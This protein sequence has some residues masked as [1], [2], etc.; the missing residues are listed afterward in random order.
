MATS[1]SAKLYMNESFPLHTAAYDTIGENHQVCPICGTHDIVLWGSRSGFQLYKC[2][3][4]TH[5][6][7]DIGSSTITE[8]QGDRFR[9]HVTNDQMASDIEYYNHLCSGEQPGKHT[10]ITVEHILT[11]LPHIGKGCGRSWLDIGCGSGYLVHR[12]RQLGLGAIGIEPGG[13]GQVAAK[14][15]YIP[16]VQGFLNKQTFLNKFDVISVTDVLE[17]QPDPEQFLL[18]IH[19][20]LLPSSYVLISFPFADSLLRRFLGTHWK[21]VAP[22]THCQFFTHKSFETLLEKTGFELV[23]LIQYNSSYLP[24]I[25]EFR[26]GRW[27]TDKFLSLVGGGDQA[28]ALIRIK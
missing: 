23:H 10:Y 16:V 17:H 28:L 27:M 9:S 8:I 4:C 3:N 11:L 25:R 15:K 24:V 14:E 7:A 5:R 21:M 20:Y 18:L 12:M 1:F 22:P 13:W 19:H 26:G 6:F 2:R